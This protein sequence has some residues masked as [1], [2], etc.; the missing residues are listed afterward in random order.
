MKTTNEE[1][2]EDLFKELKK[3]EEIIILLLGSSEQ[4]IPSREHIQKELFLLSKAIPQLAKLFRFE[5]HYEG[6][7]DYGLSDYLD[8]PLFYRDAFSIGKDGITLSEKGRVYYKKLIENDPEF[9]NMHVLMKMTRQLYDKL[10]KDELLFLIYVTYPEYREKSN[11][12]DT[13]MS[14]RKELAKKLL[15]K[16][17]ITEG[18]YQELVKDVK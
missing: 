3:K 7:Y 13:L 11:I 9:Q 8:S 16:G 6:P 12:S 17:V 1:S 18:R 5:K 4:H 15:E 2:F 10:S 14:K